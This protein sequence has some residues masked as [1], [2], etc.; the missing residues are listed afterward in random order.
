MNVL[1][2]TGHTYQAV[3]VFNKMITEELKN[4]IP[5]L[6]ISNLAELYPNY[7]I[8]RTVEREKLLWADTIII[9]SPVFWYSMT[10]LIMRYLEEVFEHG[11]AYGSRGNALKGKRIIISLTAGTPKSEYLDGSAGLTVDDVT[12]PLKVIFEFCK[13]N[14][15]GTVFSGGMF[16]TGDG[17]ADTESAAQKVRTH[18]SEILRKL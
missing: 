6:K 18:V 5:D 16:N 2:I 9:Q 3:S 10:S 12:K 13:M 4:E 8:D 14:Y 17:S 15:L 7:Q 1:L 11:W